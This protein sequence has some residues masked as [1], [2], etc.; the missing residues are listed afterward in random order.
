MSAA[1]YVLAA[2]VMCVGIWGLVHQRTLVGQVVALGIAQSSTY[3]LLLAIGYRFRAAAPILVGT[4]PS[5]TAT[6]DPVVQALCL[7][8]IV[9]SATTMALLLVF[10]GCIVEETGSLESDESSGATDV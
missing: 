1:P 2:F 9:V 8:D 5:R 10:A 3:I 7:T 4:Q 6:V